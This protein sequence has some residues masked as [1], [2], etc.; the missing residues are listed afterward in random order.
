MTA[1]V[2]LDPKWLSSKY[3]ADRRFEGVLSRWT[4][5]QIARRAELVE[6]QRLRISLRTQSSY[7]RPMRSL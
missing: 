4:P 6:K 1:N 3:R 2:P 7:L 5:E